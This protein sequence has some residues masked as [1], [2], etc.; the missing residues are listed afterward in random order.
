MKVFILLVLSIGLCQARPLQDEVGCDDPEVFEAVARAI[1][2]F[3]EDRSQGNK[4]ALNVILHAYRT[5]GPGKKFHVIYQV[6]ETACPIDADEPWQNCDLLGLSEGHY[7]NCTADIDTESQDFSSVSQ[8]CKISPGQENVERSLAKCLGCWHPIDPKSLEVLPIVRFT[9][10][11]FNNQSQHFALYEIGEINKVTRQVVNG[12]N[13]RLEYSVKETNCSKNEFP[14][15]SP[16]CR[17]LPEG[18]EGSCTVTAHVDNTNTLAHAEQDCKVQVE[19]KV[20]PPVDACFGCVVPIAKDSQELK[21]P[22]QAAIESFNAKNNSDF[23][24]K[25]VAIGEVTK[26]LVAGTK[27]RFDMIIQ[28]TNCSK[29]EVEKLNEDCTAAEDGER[30]FC[31]GSTLV[32]PWESFISS[33]V[34]CKGNGIQELIA[35]VP[36]GFTPFRSRVGATIPIEGPSVA[37]E[38]HPDPRGH[39]IHKNRRGFGHAHGHKKGRKH[40][41][42]KPTESSSEEVTVLP[43]V[44]TPDQLPTS[45]PLVE[46]EVNGRGLHEEKVGFLDVSPTHSTSTDSPTFLDHLPDLP[47]PPKCPGTPWK[48]KRDPEPLDT[49]FNDFDLLDALQK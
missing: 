16:A 15:L 29:S 41:H 39:H 2:A 28:K 40:G 18:R 10:Q 43:P 26:Q 12:W 1:K 46:Q 21:E 4:F 19:E 30:L 22:L 17:H 20:E 42:K 27:Y 9:I 37:E 49:S 31:R 47:E 44:Q 13:Y 45:K 3:N 11:Q 25:I 33:Q 14:D 48:P 32:R 38:F 5:A 24:F 6:R 8:N 23:H 34:N 35:R 7:G 36:P